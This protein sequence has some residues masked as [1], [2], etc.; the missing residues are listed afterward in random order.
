M[1]TKLA[2]RLSYLY[3]GELTATIAFI[4]LSILVHFTYPSLHLYH[5]ISFCVSFFFLE[6]L[7]IQG[8]F[9]WYTKWKRLKHENTSITPIEVVKRMKGFMKWNVLFII[10]TPFTFIVDY[11]RFSDRL[12]F[13]GFLLV[14][15]IYL[16]AIL[17]YINYYYYQLMYD[18]QDDLAHL[19]RTKRL[20]RASLSKDFDRLH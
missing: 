19:K 2:K 16:F 10:I 5:L 4:F 6:F 15:F 9:Y 18:N 8:T 13:N 3:T 17:E 11:L 7:L 1:K 12:P 20:K 14:G